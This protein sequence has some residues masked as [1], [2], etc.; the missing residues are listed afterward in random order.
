MR[1]HT[2]HRR[3]GN[4]SQVLSRLRD[5]F[6]CCEDHSQQTVGYDVL[7]KSARG[8]VFLVEIKD[9]S[10]SPSRREMSDNE[11]AMAIRWGRSYRVIKDEAEAVALAL[12]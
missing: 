7:V 10:L 2:R 9:G 8:S 12:E 11:K 5:L 1:T 3:D 6:P 4:H